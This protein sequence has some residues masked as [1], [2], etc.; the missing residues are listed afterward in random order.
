MWFHKD[1][2]PNAD[3]WVDGMIDKIKKRGPWTMKLSHEGD[4][5]RCLFVDAK[6]VKATELEITQLFLMAAAFFGEPADAE[7]RGYVNGVRSALAKLQG[8]VAAM[9]QIRSPET[10]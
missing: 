9:T 2:I 3:E 6:G 7:L 4:G 10:N 8:C 1:K 5:M